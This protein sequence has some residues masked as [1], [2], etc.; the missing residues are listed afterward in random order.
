MAI[1]L[2]K[3]ETPTLPQRLVEIIRQGC[4][5]SALEKI[6]KDRAG[7]IRKE[8]VAYAEKNGDGFDLVEQSV[9]TD[10]GCATLSERKTIVWNVDRIQELIDDG[11]V[12]LTT[13]L[14]CCSFRQ[15]DLEVALGSKFDEAISEITTKQ[16]ISFTGNSELKA[17]MEL[18]ADAIDQLGE[19]PAP[20]KPAKAEPKTEEALAEMTAEED[21]VKEAASRVRKGVKKK[22][23]KKPVKKAK[24]KTTAAS[25]DADL[26]DILNS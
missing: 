4:S 24:A 7:Q 18:R 11:T 14:G 2:K 22:A 17:D 12:T 8:F 13:I 3:D 16:T 9:N 23:A 5:Y 20:A 10:S 25:T 19:A 26:D 15:K 6:F 21:G 1:K